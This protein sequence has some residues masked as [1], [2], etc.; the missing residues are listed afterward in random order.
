MVELLKLVEMTT[1]QGLILNK[2]VYSTLA[3][4]EGKFIKEEAKSKKLAEDLKV[5]SSEN[6]KL[7]EA[8]KKLAEDHVATTERTIASVNCDFDAVV[9]EK[10][11]QLVRTKRELEKIKEELAKVGARAMRSYKNEFS[12]TLEYFRFAIHFMVADGE[13]LTERIKEVHPEWD[14]SFLMSA[15]ID[16]PTSRPSIATE[17]PFSIEPKAEVKACIVL[18][19]VEEDPKVL[20]LERW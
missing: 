3:G 6:T 8:V 1:T 13:Q 9:A 5:M 14:F 7:A 10:E 19:T 16:I 20:A 18:Y 12:S 17:V 4:F 11:K 2:E 15:P